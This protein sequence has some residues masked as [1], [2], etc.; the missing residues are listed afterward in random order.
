MEVNSANRA[1]KI[2]QEIERRLGLH[3]SYLST[4]FETPEEMR[5]KLKQF[6]AERRAKPEA[7]PE[8]AEDDPLLDPAVSKEMQAQ[9]QKEFEAWVC[10]KNPLLGGRSPLQAVGDP[11]GREMVEALLLDSERRYENSSVRGLIR[12]DLNAMRRLLKLPI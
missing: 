2:R 6:E 8:I 7:E 9:M 11:D 5:A 12:P 4:K 1:Q 10:K 3:A